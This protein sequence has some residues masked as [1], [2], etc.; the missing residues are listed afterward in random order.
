MK[1]TKPEI[2]P[3]TGHQNFI[4]A[5]L[6]LLQFTVILDFMV[7]SPLSDFLMKTLKITTTQFG[8]AVSAYAFS[9]GASGLLAVGLAN[10]FDR[11]KLLIFFYTGFVIGTFFCAFS[12]TYWMLL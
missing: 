9:A 8:Y 1:S 4:I 11:K 3:F 2:P 10:K 6:A 7:M 5:L 12:T